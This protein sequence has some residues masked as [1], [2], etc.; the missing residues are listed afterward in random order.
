MRLPFLSPG[1]TVRVVTDV[2]RGY[3]HKLKIADG[4]MYDTENLSS[5]CFPL[6]ARRPPRVRRAALHEPSGLL[7]GDTLI[8]VDDNRLYVDGE[9]T[10]LTMPVHYNSRQLVRFGSYVVIF[11]D[12]LYYNLS[13]PDDRGSLDAQTVEEG[14]VRFAPCDADGAP[15]EVR[16]AADTEPASPQNGEI[17][18]NTLEHRLLRYSLAQMAWVEIETVYTR[19]SFP[20]RGLLQQLFRAGDGVAI[21][22]LAPGE[23]NGNKYLYGLGGG[24]E[25]DDYLV[26]VGL[27]P[28]QEQQNAYVTIS[29]A[30][31]AM[32]FVIECRNRLWGCRFYDGPGTEPVNELYCSA[33]GDFKNWRQYQG[34]STDSW[35]ASIGAPG[36]W[37]GAVNYLGRPCFFKEDRVYLVSVSA[38]GGHRVEEI[39]CRG[40]ERG[41]ARS[42]CIVG[43]TLYYKAGGEVMAWQGGFPVPVSGT[44]F[45]PERY[46][47]AVGGAAGDKYYLSMSHAD[48]LT[49]DELFVYDIA[50]GLWLREDSLG[51]FWAA[52]SGGELWA[53]DTRGRLLGL[54][55]SGEGERETDADIPWRMES[56]ILYYEYPDKKYVSRYNLRLQMAAGAEARIL[57]EYDSSG[58]W[59]D[60]GTVRLRGTGTVTV[61]IRPRRCDH[62]RMKLEGT[63][64][65]KLLSVARV[66]E[67]GSDV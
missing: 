25:E 17:W 58:L 11:P 38:L 34:L 39:P 19:V 32:D 41:S 27:V 53:V 26:L 66:L 37:T 51:L 60:S 67:L 63:G 44:V 62:L 42:L 29:R 35:A 7:G 8:W 47:A 45:G 50:R 1:R 15:Y 59:I 14:T 24:A 23:L 16:T 46:C 18:L 36:V 65:M 57:L 3:N 13:D 22:G 31:P 4:E 9:A 56:G 6:L 40:V 49:R 43:E 55:G 20:S 5:D 54:T 28:A 52:A 2:F 33:L 61:P 21:T 30:A 10:E 64:E 48:D 12:N